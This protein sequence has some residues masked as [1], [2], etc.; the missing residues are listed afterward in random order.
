MS[1]DQKTQL[2]RKYAEFVMD[3]MDKET[4]KM[5]VFDTLVRTYGDYKHEELIDEIKEFYGEQW[6][7][8]H[9]MPM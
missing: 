4:M 2:V 3:G 1:Y 7:Q 5:F 6:F 9:S 8:D